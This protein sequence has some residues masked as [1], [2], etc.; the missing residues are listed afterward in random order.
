MNKRE[1][2]DI[3]GGDVE[4]HDIK[5]AK[6]KEAAEVFNTEQESLDALISVWFD[7]DSRFAI[8]ETARLYNATDIQS[9]NVPVLEPNANCKAVPG[10]LPKLKDKA[11][12]KAIRKVSG[13]IAVPIFAD[14]NCREDC[15]GFVICR[16]GESFELL[17][18]N[19]FGDNQYSR[20]ELHHAFKL[21]RAKGN[22]INRFR[23]AGGKLVIDSSIDS[24]EL[25][26]DDSF[27]NE[28]QL[29]TLE[30]VKAKL[31]VN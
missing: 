14:E 4:A 25:F 18:S 19:Q 15:L 3:F 10:F 28:G 27:Y 11:F 29:K 23:K 1:G 21:S 22:I 16:G 5:E 12:N 24:S 26:L 9:F 31:D 13:D 30:L 7:K 6:Q 17:D 20:D 2:L 8:S